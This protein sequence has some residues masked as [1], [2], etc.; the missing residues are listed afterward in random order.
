MSEII[1]LDPR[2]EEL[3]LQKATA[4]RLTSLQGVVVGMLSNHKAN[5]D[6]LFDRIAQHLTAAY[7]AAEVKRWEKPAA[8]APAAD[9][10]YAEMAAT[11]GATVVGVGD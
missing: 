5:V 8:S 2:A 3:I 10:V 9:D 6:H 4:P 11:C 1:V 7:G